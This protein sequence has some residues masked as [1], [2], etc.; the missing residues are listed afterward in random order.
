MNSDLANAIIDKDYNVKYGNKTFTTMLDLEVD[1]PLNMSHIISEADYPIFKELVDSVNLT[2]KPSCSEFAAP[3]SKKT[4]EI[5]V[6]KA[7][8]EDNIYFVCKV[9][10][11]TEHK[12]LQ[13]NLVHSQKMQAIG[14]LAGS[15]AHDFNNLLTAMIGFCDILLLKSWTI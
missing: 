14:Q 13:T 1:N 7:R 6:S 15:I 2:N 4:L 10:D 5:H 3:K 11:L 8:I 12:Q 9:F